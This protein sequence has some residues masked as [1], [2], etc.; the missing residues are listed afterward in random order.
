MP[1]NTTKPSY[2]GHRTRLRK[3][4]LTAGADA[5]LEHEL[6]ELLLTYALPRKDTKSLAWALLKNFGSLANVLDASLE[7]LRQVDGIGLQAALFLKVVR[8]SFKRYMLAEVKNKQPLKTPQTVM[9]Y[10]RT[11][12]ADKKEEFLEVI[13]LSRRHTILSTQLLASGTLDQVSVSPRQV[14]ASAL[15]ANAAALILVHNHPSG[16]ISP[17]SADIQLTQNIQRAARVFDIHVADINIMKL[18]IF[19]FYFI[20]IILNI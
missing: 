8:A 11:S 16:E 3:K 14:V 5:F 17:S 9:D 13:F 2:L 7:E 15:Q 12:L 10:C 18:N 19:K 6:L 20:S 1:T 4:F